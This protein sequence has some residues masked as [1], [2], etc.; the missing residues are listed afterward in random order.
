MARTGRAD[1][2]AALV[3]PPLD[4]TVKSDPEGWARKL[5]GVVLP[6]GS[7]RFAAKG[8]IEEMEGF[9]EGEWWVQDAAASLPAKLLGD[10]CGRRVADL[11]AA[12]GGKTAQL[13][14]A[15]AEVTAVDIS[16]KRLERLAGN[17][18]PAEADG[19][20]GRRGRPCLAARR[21]RSTPCCSTRPAPR[22]A[23]S[24][25]IPTSPI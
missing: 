3:E 10:V 5:G 19:R 4:L 25:A 6:T 20:N 1:R 14:H 22:P 24:A 23:P 11:C 2:R 21:R 15:G 12:P 8:R 9:G 16:A 17:L 7:V 18:D 13:A